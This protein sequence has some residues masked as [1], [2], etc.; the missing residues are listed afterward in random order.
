MLLVR[1]SANR[2]FLCLLSAL[3]FAAT[4][5]Q[6]TVTLKKGD[7]KAVFADNSKY[8]EHHYKGYNGI[9][10]LYHKKQDSS[11]FV[12]SFAGVNLEHIFGGDS[13]VS[14]FEPRKQPM[15]IRKL[16]GSKVEL[17]QPRT[18][19]TNV[20]SWTRFKMVAPH[21]LDVEFSFVVHDAE[22]FKHGYIGFFWASYIYQPEI[23]GIYLKGKQPG[24]DTSHWK[25]L[26]TDQHG[27]NGTHA[28]LDDTAHFYMAPDFNVVLA[29]EISA[30]RFE[31]PF[32]YGRFHSMVFGYLF[33]KPKEGVF[34]FSQSPDGAGEGQP[35]WDFH[36]LLPHFEVGKKYSINWRV[37]YKEWV[38]ERDIEKEY[39]NMKK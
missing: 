27:K 15:K 29:K 12:P 5:A 3:F 6:P 14:L 2:I 26:F 34:R 17:Y 23:L 10:E 30:C 16:S 9:A 31:K 21:Y 28:A 33:P 18:G 35:A 20:E 24:D 19:A 37:L 25:Y 7:L 13:L 11:L 38:S 36:Y 8:G 32:Y 39:E 4:R 22:M 1:L